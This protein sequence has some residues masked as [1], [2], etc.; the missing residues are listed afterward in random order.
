MGNVGLI[1]AQNH[2]SIY[3]GIHSNDFFFFNVF[4][5]PEDNQQ[6]TITSVNFPESFFWD[7]WA[8]VAQL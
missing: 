1:M 4:S 5:M 6:I 3:L 7:K 8:I 2:A